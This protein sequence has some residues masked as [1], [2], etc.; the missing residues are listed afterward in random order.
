VTSAEDGQATLRITVDI[1]DGADCLPYAD[2]IQVFAGEEEVT[3]TADK[4][5]PGVFTGTVPIVG[6]ST[7]VTVVAGAFTCES[8]C[9][10]FVPSVGRTVAQVNRDCETNLT[11][12]YAPGQ[13]AILIT[14]LLREVTDKYGNCVVPARP[15]PGV[16]FRLFV[17]SP[18]DGTPLQRVT[19]A[20]NPTAS[21]VDL[22]PGPVY[23]TADAPARL[24]DQPIELVAAGNTT[25]RVDLGAGQDVELDQLFE[26][27]PAV[28]DVKV[29]VVED[30]AD[31]NR[32]ANV[33]VRLSR[34][35]NGADDNP[36]P[37]CT[38]HE[39]VAE[40]DDVPAGTYRVE[41]G[42]DP[43]MVAG[44]TW[45]TRGPAPTVVVNANDSRG[46]VE[47]RL[48]EERHVVTGTVF[49]PNGAAAAHVLV[50][51]RTS[52]DGEVLD[53][54]VTDAAGRYE[55]EAPNAGQFY[56][57]SAQQDGRLRRVF[58][59]SVNSKA[60]LDIFSG[61]DFVETTSSGNGSG[62]G[63]AVDQ[64][65]TPFPLLVGNVDLTTGTS[66]HGQ[67]GGGGYGGGASGMQNAGVTVSAAIRDVLGYRT[68]TTDTKGFLA[69]LQRSF[70]CYDK[71]GHTVCEWTP[72]SY[73]ATIPADLGA[74][75]GAQASIFERAKVAADSIV[76]L[77]DGLTPLASDADQQD[78]D[79]I[80]SIVRSRITEIVAELSLEGGPRTQRVD[81]LFERL[82]GELP[83]DGSIVL[84]DINTVID[85]NNVPKGELGV[86]G[87]RFGMLRG[88]VNT[89]AE[90]EDFTNFLIIVDSVASLF[91]TWQQVRR[92][93]DRAVAA[94][95]GDDE[96]APFLGTQLVLISRQLGVVTE[97]VR[98]TY[99]AMDSVFLGPAERQTV[100]LNLFDEGNR[101]TTILLSEL[102]DWIDRFV[103]DEG[104]HL[105]EEAGTDG[106][107]A[108][109][110]TIIRLSTLADSLAQLK[111]KDNVT[112]PPT[113]FTARVQLAL[114]QLAG[115]LQ[116]TEE[117]ARA[118]FQRLGVGDV[119]PGNGNKFRTIRRG[120]RP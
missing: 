69:A 67:S 43:I 32:L 4:D 23:L 113:F 100:L 9:R 105:I 47:L 116:R 49:G 53:T 109:A 74:L 99:F 8:S 36:A 83:I 35:D 86:L 79:A 88:E 110:P 46:S 65:P 28:G 26:F 41:L 29:R 2:D 25:V 118:V 40:F 22:P 31:G 64:D 50:E 59:V 15:V 30:L 58:P 115:Q 93:F 78:V 72:R 57:T 104:P 98:E 56:L 20:V 13:S 97:T 90:E 85:D 14:P 101:P 33:L 106:V 52:P 27:T 21:F 7:L 17:G 107:N 51:I 24:G 11:L 89:I 38:D 63:S 102:L 91:V 66:P 81:E 55:W 68:K 103:T 10:R 54:V 60:R 111:Q 18:D 37:R 34:I 96:D 12:S 95:D 119:V 80:R 108:F 62:G 16:R 44:R 45:T 1:T 120:G 87:V 76:P 19:S 82:T 92:F 75:T 77:L 94:I 114:Q 70:T 112:V 6:A 71:P 117:L 39:G 3:L 84:V 42:S 61:D 5:E 48:V 73:A